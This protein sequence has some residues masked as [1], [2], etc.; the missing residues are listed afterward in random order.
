MAK[1]IKS[2][3]VIMCVLITCMV[4]IIPCF[5][6]RGDISTQQLSGEWR[7][8]ETGNLGDV[9]NMFSLGFAI[10]EAQA[11]QANIL[12]EP[13]SPNPLYDY[14][15]VVGITLNDTAVAFYEPSIGTRGFNEIVIYY[16]WT[17]SNHVKLFPVVIMLK[18]DG[19]TVDYM[20]NTI[21]TLNVI[22]PKNLQYLDFKGGLDYQIS[23]N[24]GTV[25]SGVM[26]LFGANLF[27]SG[28][29][30]GYFL[31]TGDIDPS[32]PTEAMKDFVDYVFELL[33]GVL[34]TKLFGWF[35][36]GTLVGVF[37]AI[38]VVLIFLKYFAGG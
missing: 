8:A 20:L 9:R 23:S 27:G 35:T 33:D 15:A 7:L 31:P 11:L 34:S 18:E 22:A 6:L 16:E 1:S 29:G 5:A 3:L 30:T 13:P 14:S 10:T 36:I 21:D 28:Y 26:S 4:M 25:K 24:N 2:L 17:N 32:T 37:V 12:Q 19:R 38:S